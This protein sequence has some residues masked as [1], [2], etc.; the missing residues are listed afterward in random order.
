MQK[1]RKEI[2]KK[3][4][5]GT[6]VVL[7][8]AAM[9]AAPIFSAKATLKQSEII[10]DATLT[11]KEKFKQTYRSYIPA[12]VTVLSGLGCTVASTIMGIKTEAGLT[13]ALAGAK[14]L[15]SDY[16]ETTKEVVGEE[17]AK[18]I[19]IAMLRKYAKDT[20]LKSDQNYHEFNSEDAGEQIIIFE[21]V[22]CQFI[23]CTPYDIKCAEMAI[24]REIAESG[25]V[26]I[27]EL[28]KNLGVVL[29]PTDRGLDA[30]GEDMGWD[31]EEY[32]MDYGTSTV[33]I[34]IG[35]AADVD[36][37]LVYPISY[38]ADP[39]DLSTIYDFHGR[40]HDSPSI[41]EK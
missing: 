19:D 36:G 16:R 3:V 4:I 2:A 37:M 30:L 33:E 24:N 15:Y 28:Y 11:K 41:E 23:E 20:L 27:N 7:S 31:V 21:P 17:K 13:A 39:V 26:Q 6:L 34:Y 40:R 1:D 9:V 18:E 25:M 14:K 10:N 35:Q 5:R 22:L 8:G 12:A 32:M 29:N 38:N